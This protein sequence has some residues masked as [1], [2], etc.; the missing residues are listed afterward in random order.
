MRI[1]F[2]HWSSEATFFVSA[3]GCRIKAQ[4]VRIVL[5]KRC[6]K[7]ETIS[8]GDFITKQKLASFAQV[9][10][11]ETPLLLHNESPPTVCVG[12]ELSKI[13]HITKNNDIGCVCMHA[14]SKLPSFIPHLAQSM[15][16][17][18]AK[19]TWDGEKACFF[20]LYFLLKVVFLKCKVQYT[21]WLYTCCQQQI[22]ITKW[23]ILRV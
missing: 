18:P 9:R 14:I 5:K 22:A 11:P 16:S 8:Q 17:F 23:F 12:T 4:H 1:T 19:I 10:P 21:S 7:C 6:L 15:H 20:C 2:L 3:Y 13:G